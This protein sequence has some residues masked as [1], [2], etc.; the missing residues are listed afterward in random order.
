MGPRKGKGPCG[1]RRRKETGGVFRLRK[2]KYCFFHSD[3]TPLWLTSLVTFLFSDKKVTSPFY[4]HIFLGNLQ[5]KIY[6]QG[7]WNVETFPVEN[8]G[9]E[10]PST[11]PVEKFS[12]LNI[13]LWRK[14]HW[15]SKEKSTFPH[16]FV[17]LLLR[18]P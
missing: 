5:S 18:L 7:L 4:G 14:K 17:L 12:D 9:A 2:T 8:S 11:D 16:N 1:E 3:E 6:P 10:N 15:P 13:G